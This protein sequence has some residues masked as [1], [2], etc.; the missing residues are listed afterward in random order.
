[1]KIYKFKA[2]VWRWPGVGGWH[3]VYVDKS[4]TEELKKKGV[5]YRYGSGFVAIRATVGKTSWD[6][7]LFPHTKE[8][9]YL[10]SIK[11][12]VRKKEEIFD[13]DTVNIKFNFR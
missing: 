13:G 1:M 10:L 3:F 2:K 4:L 12:V 5:R 7:A 11:A 9:T 6:T 8:N